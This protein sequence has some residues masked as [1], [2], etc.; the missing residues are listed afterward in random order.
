LD[1]TQE[2]TQ[3]NSQ[4]QNRQKDHS[5]NESNAAVLSVMVG[6][7]AFASVLPDVIVKL[8]FGLALCFLGLLQGRCVFD[9]RGFVI[10]PDAVQLLNGIADATLNPTAF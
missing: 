4:Q 8:A 6:V 5:I 9:L 10:T 1:K 7:S 2:V 3:E